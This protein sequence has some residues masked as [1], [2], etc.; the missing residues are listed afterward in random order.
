LLSGAVLAGLSASARAQFANPMR[1]A[2]RANAQTGG[3]AVRASGLGPGMRATQRGVNAYAAG[4]RRSGYWGP[5]YGYGYGADRYAMYPGMGGA[6]MGTADVIQAEGQ[7]RVNNEQSKLI[8]EDVERS[9]LD[10]KR[11]KYEQWMWERENLPTHNEEEARLRA[12]RT[13]YVLADPP[14]TEIWSGATLNTLLGSLRPMQDQF[15]LGPSVG[16]EPDLLKHINVTTGTGGGGLGLLKTGPELDWPVELQGDA[17]KKYRDEL[18]KFSAQALQE[19]RTGRVKA[20]TVRGIQGALD[21]MLGTLKDNVENVTPTDYI[22]SKRYVNQL[23]ESLKSL[24]DPNAQKYLN[25]TYA[26]KGD[27]VGELVAYMTRNGLQF[28]AATAGDEPSYTSLHHSFVNYYNG[29]VRLAG[30]PPTSP[31]LKR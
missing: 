3:A 24:Q 18:D 12:M 17:Y 20:T 29:L 13:E 2:E 5:G 11:K 1:S 10:T 28:A 31:G 14:L 25:G 8:H 16:L 21:A 15:G 4:A 30:I 22:Q 7:F 27:S 19:A 9:K 6:L 26:A 23:K